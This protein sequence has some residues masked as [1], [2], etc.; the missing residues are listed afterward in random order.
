MSE[1]EAETCER[2]AW[3]SPVSA[4]SE[5]IQKQRRSSCPHVQTRRLSA[6]VQNCALDLLPLW[7]LRDRVTVAIQQDRTGVRERG[8]GR[9]RKSCMCVCVCVDLA[10][11]IIIL[12]PALNTPG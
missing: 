6:I 8:R 2:A 5:M 3:C 12:Y 4:V 7:G 10:F 1:R 11:L 9:E